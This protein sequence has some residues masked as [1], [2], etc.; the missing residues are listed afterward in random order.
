MLEI[1]DMRPINVIA[2]E[3]KADWKN[4]SPYAR[5]YLL[6]MLTLE[7][8]DDKYGVDYGRSIVCYFLANAAGWKGDVARRVKKELNLMVR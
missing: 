7:K 8:L 1:I 6:S 2:K 4:V 5:P 3:I